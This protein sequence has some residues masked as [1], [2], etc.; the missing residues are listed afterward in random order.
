VNNVFALFGALLLGLAVGGGAVYQ[1]LMKPQQEKALADV[2]AAR[3]EANQAKEAAKG[4]MEQARAAAAA[5]SKKTLEASAMAL[6]EANRKVAELTR[7]LDVEKKKSAELDAKVAEL[8]APK[9]AA[10]MA[11]APAPEAP[12]AESAPTPT[13]AA[14]AGPTLDDLKKSLAQA[15]AALAAAQKG[16]TDWEEEQRRQGFRG[17]SAMPD[18]FSS[19]KIK[20]LQEKVDNLQF[21]VDSYGK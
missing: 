4:A 18:E 20:E 8:Q 12:K 5:A 21:K 15:Q 19:R 9:V 13:A 7:A 6:D 2:E 17:S 1:E 14:P 3:T 10:P 16:R 11:A